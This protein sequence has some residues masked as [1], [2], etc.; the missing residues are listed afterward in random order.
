MD[1]PIILIVDD[2]PNILKTLERLFFDEDY[3]IHTATSG[4]AALEMIDNGLT[5]TVI[6]SDQRMPQMSG[7]EFLAAAKE[8]TPES[9]R[10]VLTGYADVGAAIDAI[11]IGGVYRYITKPWD[12][13]DLKLAV[14]E[15]VR[16]Y[17]LEDENRQLTRELQQANDSLE[18]INAHLDRVVQ[19]RTHALERKVREL[20]GR[21]RIQQLLLTMT[22]LDEFLKQILDE[23][24]RLP[25]VAGGAFLLLEEGGD[26][27]R[28]A[29]ETAF[30]KD[31]K[32]D[33]EAVIAK[34]AHCAKT[35]TPALYRC[36]CSMSP[37]GM[38]FIPLIKGERRFGVLALRLRENDTLPA[39]DEASVRALATLALI[40][41]GDA[42]IH[43]NLDE[44]DQNLDSLLDDLDLEPM[45]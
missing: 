11:N 16:R 2:E 8:K 15:A 12:D 1:T 35:C 25:S 33:R 9:V 38:A 21:D 40:G 27:V 28:V 4:A 37:G 26:E 10:I 45:Q 39:D 7:A 31:G 6:I 18:A 22:P 29:C 30:F 3:D 17:H 20:E 5:P 36:D 24:G 32:I 34:T 43:D 14:R 41:I 23:I 19:E 42:R 13:D 44:I